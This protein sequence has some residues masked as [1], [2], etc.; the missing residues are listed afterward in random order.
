MNHYDNSHVADTD[1]DPVTCSRED[2][3][4]VAQTNIHT[5]TLSSPSFLFLSNS[6]RDGKSTHILH[7]GK[8]QIR[9]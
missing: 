2:V 8:S 9:C 5:H 7:S 4:A 3:I 1:M 6:L